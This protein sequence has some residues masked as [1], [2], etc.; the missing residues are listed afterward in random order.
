MGLI[1]GQSADLRG[2]TEVQRMHILSAALEVP[3]SPWG[4][5]EA[6]ALLQHLQHKGCSRSAQIHWKCARSLQK[7]SA[8]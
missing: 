1:N 2:P 8:V 6:L 5:L 3:R 7:C 4:A